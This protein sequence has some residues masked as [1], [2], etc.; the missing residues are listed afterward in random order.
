ML[1]DKTLLGVKA[2]G[3]ENHISPSLGGLARTA[4]QAGSKILF[5][6]GGT[7]IK[8]LSQSLLKYSHNTIHII[9]PFDSGGSSAVI[10]EAFDIMAVGDLRNRLLSLVESGNANAQ[11]AVKFLSLRFPKEADNHELHKELWKIARK[12]DERLMEITPNFRDA[13][14]RYLL[15]FA[16]TMPKSFDLRNASIGNLFLSGC[17]IKNRCILPA[18]E[19]F[20]R[21]IDAKGIVRPVTTEDL[22]LVAELEDGRVIAGQHLITGKSV[23]P[24]DSKI[25]QI[26]LSRFAS[27]PS[28][29]R[30]SIGKDVEKLI[31]VS[32]LI[33]YPMGSFYSSLIANLLPKGVGSAIAKSL[34]LKVYIPN[35]GNDPECFGMSVAEGVEKLLEYLKKD[36]PSARI[37]DLLNFVVIDSLGGKYEGGVDVGRI[38]KLGVK[39]LDLPLVS[40][41]AGSGLS[42]N[43][44]ASMLV[45]LAS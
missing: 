26:Y 5:F 44:L 11:S 2:S 37:S 23:E 25:K 29:Y 19:K 36:I 1:F 12:E 13:I 42:G 21:F 17:F 28:I 22:Q 32:D 3:V 16:E 35:T 14:E 15:Y 30:P 24:L 6:S 4:P 8:N 31:G 38:E 41:E 9:T 33:C 20:S 27:K 10:R 39:V 43:K 18:I 7:A 34:A 45:L 40:P